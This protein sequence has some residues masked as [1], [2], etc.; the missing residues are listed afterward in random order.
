MSTTVVSNG[1]DEEEDDDDFGLINNNGA[2]RTVAG[3]AAGN[4]KLSRL[5]EFFLFC[6]KFSSL[7]IKPNENLTQFKK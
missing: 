7:L 2:G 5:I 1:Y 4:N 3:Q 6:H